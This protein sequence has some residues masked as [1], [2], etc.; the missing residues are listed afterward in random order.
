[1]NVIHQARLKRVEFTFAVG[2]L[3][4]ADVDAIVSSEQT[5]FILSGNA[6]SIS[7]Q[8]WH[9]YGDAIQR[10][11]DEA[12]N[13]EMCRA[14]TVL[15]TTGGDE[16][17]RIFHAGFHEPADWPNVPDGS[18]VTDYFEAIGSCINQVLDAAL[19]QGLCSVAFPLIGC[20]VFGLDE[21]MLVLQFL[22]AIETFDERLKEGE[23]LNVWLVIRDRGQFESVVGCLLALLLQQRSQTTVIQ[24]EPTGVS[25]LDRFAARLIQRSSEE[26]AK[27]QVC[28]FAEI[29]LEIMC[30]SLCRAAEPTPSPETLFKEGTPATFGSIREHALRFAATSTDKLRKSWGAG[31]F[32]GVLRNDASAHALETL[33][34]QRNN[35]AHGRNCL[36]VHE[37][38]ELMLQ[39]LQLKD[40]KNIQQ[41]DG[42]LHLAE[43]TPW[44]VSRSAS[45]GQT[46]LFERW[47]KHAIRYLVPETGEVFKVPR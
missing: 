42:E 8:I 17:K 2:D 30:Y 40:W 1:M 9:R 14:G 11:L 38:R 34:S 13:N 47:Q 15:D 21:K 41:T 5:D 39:A 46:G 24:I 35:L 12:T 7:G 26:W 23:S 6:E 10:E 4:D 36:C 27:W 19:S 20:G 37:I 25:A 3:F 28:R 43:W 16:F 29:A 32:A 33:N 22:D 45:T 18:S 44:V 31:F